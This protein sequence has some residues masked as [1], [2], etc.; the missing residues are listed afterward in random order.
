MHS[1]NN[2]AFDGGDMVS[3]GELLIQLTDEFIGHRELAFELL[4]AL[5]SFG[6]DPRQSLSRV[7]VS[8]GSNRFREGF[9]LAQ[10]RAHLVEREPER[11]H[12]SDHQDLLDIGLG[13]EARIVRLNMLLK[14]YGYSR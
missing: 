7:P 9:D 13:V 5:G 3:S 12:P 1:E 4:A 10:R 6:Q 2:G 8:I 11:L 14:A